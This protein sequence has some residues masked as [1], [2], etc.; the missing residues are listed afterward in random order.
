[1]E[2]KKSNSTLRDKLVT[3]AAYT[4]ISLTP[5]ISG[6]GLDTLALAAAGGL[7]SVQHSKESYPA[8]QYTPVKQEQ[9]AKEDYSSDSFKQKYIYDSSINQK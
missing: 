5:L 6:C 4:A 7:A 9:T 1:M 8:N 2:R 3:G